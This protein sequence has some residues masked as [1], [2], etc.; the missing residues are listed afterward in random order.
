MA[1]CTM[2]SPGVLRSMNRTPSPIQSSPA[3][4][5]RRRCLAATIAMSLMVLPSLASTQTV[6]GI[7]TRRCEAFNRALEK[8]SEAAIDAYLAWAQ[9][10]LSGVNTHAEL[11]RDIQI[12]HGGLLHWLSNYCQ[13]SPNVLYVEA[14]A[15][16]VSE[17]R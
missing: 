8:N 17:W 9:G 15:Q 13:S 4:P 12:D 14:L 1:P 3:Q 16:I 11:A 2:A 10:Y 6:S 7:G 5:S